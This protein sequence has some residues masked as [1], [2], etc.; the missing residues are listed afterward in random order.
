VAVN[1]Q[2]EGCKLIRAA[3]DAQF[4]VERIESMFADDLAAD[5]LHTCG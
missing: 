2:S 4:V 5:T 1:L 3:A